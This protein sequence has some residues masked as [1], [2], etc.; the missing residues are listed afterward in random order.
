MSEDAFLIIGANAGLGKDAAHQLALREGVGTIFLAC[1]DPAKAYAAR[2]DLART[3][4]KAIFEVL[5]ESP[6]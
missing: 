6:W 1:R 4:N 5:I 2:A 3:T